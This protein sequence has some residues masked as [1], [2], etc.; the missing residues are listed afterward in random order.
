MGRWVTN[1]IYDNGERL[2]IQKNE[3]DF[4]GNKIVEMLESPVALISG[5]DQRYEAIIDYTVQEGLNPTT[6]K[7]ELKI[8]PG[9]LDYYLEPGQTAEMRKTIPGELRKNGEKIPTE[10]K[11]EPEL[12][13]E[14]HDTVLSFNYSDPKVEALAEE[15]ATLTLN[16]H[17]IK[18]TAT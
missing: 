2:Y 3:T 16:N 11:M 7:T 5:T 4:S 18:E 8:N 10:V 13:R 1:L 15:S 12:Y 9:A 17:P 6:P 14:N